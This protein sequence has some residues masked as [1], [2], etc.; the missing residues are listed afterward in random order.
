MLSKHR[1]N[2]QNWRNNNSNPSIYPCTHLPIHL[3][4]AWFWVQFGKNMHEFFK[5]VKIVR[6]QRTKYYSRSL[7]NSRMCEN[8]WVWTSMDVC[9]HRCIGVNI[10]GCWW[11]SMNVGEHRWI[12]VNI[13]EWVRT[14]MDVCEHWWLGVNIDGWVW[15]SMDGCEHRW[16]GVNID[17]WVWTSVHGWVW[18]TMDVCEHK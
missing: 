6:V 10:D 12:G 13:D 2:L 15:T 18:T 1:G 9:G 5:D 17:G 16:M 4:I 3:S 7:K 14:S 8:R 11:T